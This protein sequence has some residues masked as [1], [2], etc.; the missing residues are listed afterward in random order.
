LLRDLDEHCGAVKLVIT[1]NIPE[2]TALSLPGIANG[3]PKGFGANHNAAFRRCDTTYFC[4][5][6]PDIRL[7]S[8]PFRPLLQALEQ[9][10]PAVAGPL[11]RAPSGRIEDSARRFPTAASLARKAVFPGMHGPD[12]P[13]DRGTLEVDWLAGMFMLFRSGAFRD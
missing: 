5:C 12:Y 13:T 8:D 10:R 2:R 3:T 6:N 11:V 7:A 9:G 1:E 4:V